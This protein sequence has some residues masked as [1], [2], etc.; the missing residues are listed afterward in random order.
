MAVA[1]HALGHLHRLVDRG[2]RGRRVVVAD[3]HARL[4]AEVPHQHVGV[5]RARTRDRALRFLLGRRQLVVLEQEADQV[6]VGQR[7]CVSRARP[8]RLG[9]RLFELRA[10]LGTA[11]HQRQDAARLDALVDGAELVAEL[12]LHRDRAPQVVERQIQVALREV[13]RSQVAQQVGR[14]LVLGARAPGQSLFE[15]VH[16]RLQVAPAQVEDA[17]VVERDGDEP[18]VSQRLGPAARVRVGAQRA[19]QVARVAGQ[20]AQVDDGP[21]LQLRVAQGLVGAPCLLD[22]GTALRVAAED[23][24]HVRRFAAGVGRLARQAGPIG[25][26]LRQLEGRERSVQFVRTAPLVPRIEQGLDQVRS[27]LRCALPDQ[28]RARIRVRGQ[29]LARER[30][31]GFRDRVRRPAGGR[32]QR[33]GHEPPGQRARPHERG[34]WGS[35]SRSQPARAPLLEAPRTPAA[36]IMAALSVESAMGGTNSGRPS[37]SA[38]AR[39]PRGAAACWRPRRR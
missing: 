12:L 27:R 39:R 36:P 6:G 24:E 23:R 34:R 29:Q 3:Q 25:H 26:V 8:V 10:R 16:R 11:T 5:G 18:L 30:P 28:A 13:H 17:R 22:V 14:E 15:R 35:A 20:D 32:E 9:G 21:R 31:R 33:G 4:Q 38:S 1:V 37:S 2:Q 7:R 19:V